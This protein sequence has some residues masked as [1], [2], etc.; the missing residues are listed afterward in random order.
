M[1]AHFCDFG[2]SLKAFAKGRIA[3]SIVKTVRAAGGIL[4]EED[5]AS[6]KAR[7]EPAIKGTYRNRT[8][9]TSGAPS[10]GPVLIGLLNTLEPIETFVEEGR[11]GLNMHRFV[12]ALKCS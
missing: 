7:V 9:Y 10:S 2:F 12:E 1:Y 3:K 4:T 11:T 5:L 8:L 6:Y